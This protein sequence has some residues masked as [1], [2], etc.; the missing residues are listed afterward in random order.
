M[1]VI[2]CIYVCRLCLVSIKGQGMLLNSV[3]YV[4]VNAN[5]PVFIYNCQLLDHLINFSALFIFFV[6]FCKL[7][8][9]DNEIGKSRRAKGRLHFF[10][11]FKDLLDI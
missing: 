1:L 7:C 8:Q 4:T 10:L 3:I 2:K 11:V 6:A 9:W 5:N